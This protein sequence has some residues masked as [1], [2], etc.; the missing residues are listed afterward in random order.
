MK[1]EATTVVGKAASAATRHADV[2]LR[3]PEDRSRT[4]R[5]KTYARLIGMK[6]AF[7]NSTDGPN[8]AKSGAASHAITPRR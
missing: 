3:R 5:M 7:S 4:K 6:G 1:D 8:T 2:L